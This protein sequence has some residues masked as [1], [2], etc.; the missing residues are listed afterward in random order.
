[1]FRDLIDVGDN[2]PAV[3]SFVGAGGKTTALFTLSRELTHQKRLITTTTAIYHPVSSLWDI[4]VI[5]PNFLDGFDHEV[6]KTDTVTVW[7]QSLNPENKLLGV[8]TKCLTQVVQTDLFDTI[9]VE[10]DGSK[11]RPIKA[12]AK[13][14]PV[15]PEESTAVV[16]I[17]GLSSLNKPMNNQWVHRVEQFTNVVH[18]NSGDTVQ[19]EHI[20][21]L[22]TNR[23]GLFRDAPTEACKI[24]VLNQADNEWDKIQGRRIIEKV[25]QENV[26]ISKF[27]ITSFNPATFE[28][29]WGERL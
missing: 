12:P 25:K 6:V 21:R 16:G 27:V 18:A 23:D 8:S 15:I 7:G 2:K 11:H 9:L 4:M 13:H 26:N 17:I 5:R 1:V 29:V 24:L 19:P 10:A 3:I 20:V 22:V 28:L 14:E